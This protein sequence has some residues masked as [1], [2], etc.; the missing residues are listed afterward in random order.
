MK[1]GSHTVKMVGKSSRPSCLPTPPCSSLGI[2]RALT[3]ARAMYEG[4]EGGGG[5]DTGAPPMAP[6]AF[7]KFNIYKGKGALQLRCV[8]LCGSLM[9][10]LHNDVRNGEEK[11]L[12][13]SLIA[14]TWKDTNKGTGVFVDREGVVYLEFASVNANAPQQVPPLCIPLACSTNVLC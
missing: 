11:F 13:R 10:P 12:A 4:S 14:P 1:I 3:T 6:R 9:P 7:A 2:R 8:C 5:Y